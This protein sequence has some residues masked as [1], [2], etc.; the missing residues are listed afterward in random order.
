MRNSKGKGGISPKEKAVMNDARHMEEIVA[1]AERDT[2]RATIQKRSGKKPLTRRKL[3]VSDD[4]KKS[5]QRGAYRVSLKE[6]SKNG[7]GYVNSLHIKG[8]P[9][10]KASMSSHVAFKHKKFGRIISV[11]IPR[12]TSPQR[13]L[14]SKKLDNDEIGQ[15]VKENVTNWEDGIWFSR[16]GYANIISDQPLNLNKNIVGDVLVSSKRVEQNTGKGEKILYFPHIIVLES[17]EK[18]PD[19]ELVI[20]DMEGENTPGQVHIGPTIGALRD[21]KEVKEY[22]HLKPCR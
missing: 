7:E 16:I 2:T 17:Q 4:G 8:K 3:E 5:N 11:I 22:L 15:W 12:A 10:I 21:N 18:K 1:A 14:R 19:F 20:D 9:D 13:R 6:I